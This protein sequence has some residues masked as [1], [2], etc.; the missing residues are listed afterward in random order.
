MSVSLTDCYWL[1]DE[2]T[3]ALIWEDIDPH[4]NDFSQEIASAVV[5]G[6]YA[7]VTDFR[8]PDLTTD[9]LLKKA[10]V[11]AGGVPSLVKFGNLGVNASGK[12]LLSANEVAAYRIAQAMGL[13]HAEYSLMRIAGTKETACITPCFIHDAN[14][15][16]VTAHQIAEEYRLDGPGLY[17]FFA[18]AGM[19]RE[20]DHMIV[21][22]HLIHNTDRHERNFGVIRDSDSLEILGFAPLFDSG[23]S[24]GWN[25]CQ[26]TVGQG[27]YQ[28]IREKSD[29]AAWNGRC[30]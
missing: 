2:H 17:R 6:S 9:G 19:K 16:F 25:W 29:G 11:M 8:S 22:D 21:F 30:G 13:N 28:A 26:D 10:W 5:H 27:R 3:S 18:N 20:V 14:D 12:N 15:E 7:P 24:F 1:N 23:S 4:Q